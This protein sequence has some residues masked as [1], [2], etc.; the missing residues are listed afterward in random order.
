MRMIYTFGSLLIG[1]ALATNALAQPARN[2]PPQSGRNAP[3]QSAN[4][5]ATRPAPAPLTPEAAAE[6][7]AIQA[8]S[9]AVQNLNKAVGPI[10][11]L[12]DPAQR[13]ELA[14][15]AIGPLKEVVAAAEKLPNT[16]MMSMGGPTP[17]LTWR[18]RYLSL[19]GLLDDPEG[20]EKL[21]KSV[22]SRD[23]DEALLAKAYLA[24]VRYWKAS[25]DEAEQLKVIDDLTALANANAENEKLSTALAEFNLG[26]ASKSVRDQLTSIRQ[27]VMQTRQAK[28]MK[29]RS[30]IQASMKA[31]EG[32]PMVLKGRTVDGKQFST[33]DLKG[34]VILVD[35]WATWCAPC[36]AEL[37]RVKKLYADY[38]DKDL[39]ILGVS[40]DRSEAALTTYLA[41]NPD[42]PWTQ[43][44]E[45]DAAWHPLAKQYGVMGIPTMFVIDRN[46]VCR[47]VTARSN[48]EKLIPELLAEKAE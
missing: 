46:G 20:Q 3:P 15:K 17:T 24:L 10:S 27:D 45:P 11:K 14:P 31:L 25:G 32:K 4:G 48:M 42:M 7:A 18:F 28:M 40:C 8:Y 6:R 44:F 43:L 9:Q 37:P 35:F 47:S 12:I 23:A 30:E 2:A 21:Q 41:K 39:E 1:V 16:V 34:K 36:I 22:E 13:A 29:D 26:A 5:P 19:L 33:A 38:H